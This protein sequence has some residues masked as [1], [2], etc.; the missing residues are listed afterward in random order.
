MKRFFSLV[1]SVLLL[2]SCSRSAPAGAPLAAPA[3][4]AGAPPPAATAPAIA[5]GFIISAPGA[6]FASAA[7]P[8][9]EAAEATEVVVHREQAR[10]TISGFGGAFNEHGWD[11]LRLL[12]EGERQEVLA[13]LF[14]AGSGLGLS[15]GR[16]PIGASDYAL[17]RYTLDESPGD[18]D[19]S[20]FSI[21]RDRRL[22]I[23]YVQAAVK[24]R[25]D[26]RL[27]GSA[28]TPPTWMKTNGAFDSGAIKDDPKV[29]EAYALYLAR[30]VESYRDE[31]I[32]VSMVVPQNEPGQLTRYP[33]CDW[34]PAQYVTFI[35]DHLA[36]TFR[37]R[38]LPTQIFVGTVNKGDWDVLAVLKAPG[39]ASAIAGVGLQWGGLEHV[40]P[41]HA[42]YPSL[43]IMQSET[44]CGNQY[45]QPDYNPDTP[46]NDFAYAAYTFRKLRDFISA[47]A[48]SYMLWNLVLDEHG[49]NLDSQRPWPQNSPVVVDRAT[50][51]VTYTPMYW[52]TK[53]FSGLIRVGARVIASSSSYADQ[54]AF[55]NPDG[56]RVVE[57]LNDSAAPVRLVIVDGAR[58]Q[59][60]ELP[61]RSVASL[62]LPKE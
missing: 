5:P 2:S 20:E 14:D 61:A 7:L 42:A 8:S 58:R 38:A 34:T 47:G 26:L 18:F 51:Q 28:W 56:T 12:P 49:K 43:P 62:I 36:P 16:I 53:H 1:A 3:P 15:Y 41:V 60:L 4:G 45:R 54:I 22:L 23:P 6:P 50:K 31:G 39:L 27:W 55:E 11:V 35:R 40:A 44:E 57:L 10:H 25:P 24:L 13:A 37:R 33:S 52:V 32:T 29:Y 19:M 9:V 30:F 48:S 21:E 46:P 17:D 59:P